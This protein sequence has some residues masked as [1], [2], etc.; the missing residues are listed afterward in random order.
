MYVN[1]V[2]LCL[3]FQLSFIQEYAT[4]IYLIE[5]NKQKR[6]KILQFEKYDHIRLT[7]IPTQVIPETRPTCQCMLSRSAL[8][9]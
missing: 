6:A 2:H 3:I 4:S 7:Q 9:E 5:H 8:Y 1:T